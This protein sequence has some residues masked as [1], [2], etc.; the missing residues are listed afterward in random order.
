MAVGPQSAVFKVAINNVVLCVPGVVPL[1]AAITCECCDDQELGEQQRRHHPSTEGMASV[2]SSPLSSLW[3]ACTTQGL[4]PLRADAVE[5][6][7]CPLL[8]R[9]MGCDV[10]CWVDLF[11]REF[12][13]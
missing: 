6:V 7:C 9:S 11:Q 2:Q 4:N 8:L 5:L 10:L 12:V 13:F 1:S 3:H